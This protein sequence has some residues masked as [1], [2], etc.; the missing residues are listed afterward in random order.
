MVQIDQKNIII[1]S[2]DEDDINKLMKSEY[3]VTPS[4]GPILIKC[5]PIQS[6]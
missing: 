3:V 1:I 2:L 5:K 4:S 6:Q